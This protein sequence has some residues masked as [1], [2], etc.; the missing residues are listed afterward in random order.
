MSASKLTPE[1]QRRIYQAIRAGNYKEVACQFAGISGTTLR[2]WVN[3]GKESREAGTDNC[4]Y[5]HFLRGLEEAEAEAEVRNVAVIQ[6]AAE[7]QWQASAWMLERRHPGR[8]ARNDKQRLEV[9]AEVDV[10]DS[11]SKDRLQSILDGI[12]KRLGEEEGDSEFDGGGSES[13]SV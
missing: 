7:K 12:A 1:A 5:L 10:N 13:D 8:W 9:K 2:N 3:R 6:K 11:S 4:K